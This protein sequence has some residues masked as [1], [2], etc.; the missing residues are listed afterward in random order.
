MMCLNSKNLI[1]VGEFLKQKRVDSDLTQSQVAEA[2]GYTSPQFISNWERGL[3]SPPLD[4]LDKICNMYEI[5][6]EEFIALIIDCT[7]SSMLELLKVKSVSKKKRQKR[8]S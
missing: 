1:I 5:D 4:Q 7:K 3:C 8:V 6:K 2:L